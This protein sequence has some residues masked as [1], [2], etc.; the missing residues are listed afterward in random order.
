MCMG[1]NP[2][3][4]RTQ[5][6]KL[7]RREE[8]TNGHYPKTSGSRVPSVRVEFDGWY[9]EGHWRIIQQLMSELSRGEI[10]SFWGD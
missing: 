6:Q 1:F 9:H 8:V 5:H 10:L 4:R 2:G 7:T 3:V